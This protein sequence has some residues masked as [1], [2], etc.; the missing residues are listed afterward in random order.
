MASR[1]S[2]RLFSLRNHQRG[3]WA[4][5]RPRAPAKHSGR[6]LQC[7]R[8]RRGNHYV[9]PDGLGQAGNVPLEG[10]RLLPA[11]RREVGIQPT[12]VEVL[13]FVC[14]ARDIVEAL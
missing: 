10:R 6:S 11:V 7:P 8:E 3:S 12:R 5:L 1:K 4:G 9:R 13:S 2:H 14:Q